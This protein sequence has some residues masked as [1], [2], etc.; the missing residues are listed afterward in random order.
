MRKLLVLA[1]IILVQ[2]VLLGILIP[3]TFAANSTVKHPN[4]LQIK[5]KFNAPLAWQKSSSNRSIQIGCSGEIKPTGRQSCEGGV[6]T[7]KPGQTK[8]LGNCSCFGKQGCLVVGKT[9]NR[10]KDTKHNKWVV[11]VASGKDIKSTL[12]NKCSVTYVNRDSQKKVKLA[13][14]CGT[15]KQKFNIGINIKCTPNKPSITPT[16]T[17]TP[18]KGICVGP[19]PVAN[20]KVTCPSC[21]GNGLTPTPT[22]AQTQAELGTSCDPNGEVNQCGSGLVCSDQGEGNG[23]CAAESEESQ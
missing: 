15:N 5:V 16:N 10:S 19:K 22:E 9:L 13:S 23:I 8:T 21:L 2:A 11:T 1:G 20:V 4:C 7:V 17:P 12:G 6:L 3:K 14:I 18:T